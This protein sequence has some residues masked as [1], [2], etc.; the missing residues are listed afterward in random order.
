VAKTRGEYLATNGSKLA[1]SPASTAA[2]NS[3]SVRSIGG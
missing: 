3:A 1:L 2:I